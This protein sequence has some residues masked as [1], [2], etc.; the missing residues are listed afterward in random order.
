[1][2]G[3]PHFES[4]AS[5]REAAGRSTAG[6][7]KD[8]AL[9]GGIV[10]IV[11]L[12]TIATTDGIRWGWYIP[13]L[14]MA[15]CFGFFDTARF[16]RGRAD[17]LDPAVL[18]G[19]VWIPLFV[20][21]PIKQLA[22]D[23]WPYVP[24]LSGSMAWIDLWAVM[25]LAGVLLFQVGIRGRLSMRGPAAPLLTGYLV[26]NRFKLSVILLLFLVFGLCCQL[27]VYTK[28]GGLA[29]FVQTFG[30][31]QAAGVR[32]YDPFAGMGVPM[33]LADSFKL[34]FAIAV[35]LWASSKPLAKSVWFLGGMMLCLLCVALLFG[36]LK[37]S[38]S[39]TLFSLF[40]AAGFYHLRIRP[41]GRMQLMLA[42]AFAF[43]FVTGYYWYKIAGADGLRAVLDD[44][45]RLEFQESRREPIKYVVA[46]DLGRM[47]VQ[48][49]ALREVGAESGP[50]Y[51]LGRTYLASIFA[52][53]PRFVVPWKPDQI[54]KEKT[55]ILYGR[56]SYR[57]DQARQ[58]TLV[59]GQFGEAFVNFSYLG[60]GAFYLLLGQSVRAYRHLRSRLGRNDIRAFILPALCLLPVLLVITDVNV[61]AQQIMRYLMVPL[62]VVA[63]ARISKAVG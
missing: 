7:G 5:L 37:G 44:S 2:E 27:Y 6:G 28:F 33:I 17:F 3:S 9:S 16:L 40:C 43:A 54:T 58:T 56:G 55:E 59:L 63:L 25:N 50:D 38:R 4:Y 13:A 14:T 49:L 20:V 57:A 12:L 18:I 62:A 51:A 31:R 21:S 19:L 34:T 45:A 32:D 15:A 1:M 61:V 52:V 24:S 46:R 48:V 26:R 36:G 11:L 29:G 60:V 30:D 22:W 47:D 23:Y 42:A 8:L 10:S 41:I 35:V 53:I 39:A